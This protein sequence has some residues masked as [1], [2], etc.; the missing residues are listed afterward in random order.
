MK[1]VVINARTPCLWNCFV[2]SIPAYLD[3]TMPDDIVEVYSPPRIVP[4]APPHGLRAS[5]SAD[6]TTGWDLKTQDARVSLMMQIKMRKPTVIVSSP[7]CTMMSGI[8]NLNWSKMTREKRERLFYEG[9]LHLNFAMILCDYQRSRG[10]FF[11]HE[12][13]DNALSWDHSTVLDISKQNDVLLARFHMCY[14]GL[15]SKVTEIPVQKST[16]VMTNMP[17]VHE[18]LNGC[19]CPGHKLHQILQGM[20]GGMKRSE[21]SQQYPDEFCQAILE[22]VKGHMS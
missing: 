4:L 13:P 15:K 19:N 14:F 21:W 5:L 20:E 10:R 1:T 22:A 2:A 9:L 3:G 7:P 6:L 17:E 18:K 11:V 16:K 12:H 8:Q